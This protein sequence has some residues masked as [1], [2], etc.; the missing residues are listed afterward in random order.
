MGPRFTVASYKGAARVAQLLPER[1]A[2]GAGSAIG[3]LIPYVARGRAT[4]VA[5]HQRRIDPS[6]PPSGPL[7]RRQ[8]RRTFESYAC[9]MVDSFRLP[10]MSAAEIDSRVD[11]EGWHHVEAGLADG[12]GLVMAMPHLGAWDLGGAWF[13]ARTPLTV[14]AEA[15]EPPELFDWFVQHRHRLGITVVPLGPDATGPLVGALRRNE[16]LGLLC[17]R[18]ITG[19]GIEVTFFGERTTVPGGPATLALRTGAPILPNAAVYGPGRR[20]RA[21][22]RPPIRF[23]RRGRLRDDV[24]ALTQL[25]VVELEALIREHP[26]QWHVLQPNWPTDPGFEFSTP[27]TSHNAPVTHAPVTHAPDTDESAP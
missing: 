11:V 6:L 9:S 5:I 21:I 25:V 24:T 23:E 15:L 27:S 3:S 17:D 14:V 1:F 20:I 13:A 8:V 18:D 7:L 12:K 19:G 26:E 4:Q 10:S 2:L 16:C 22:V